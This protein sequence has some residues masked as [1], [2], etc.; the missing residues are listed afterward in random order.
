MAYV[1]VTALTFP[2]G[3]EA[4]IEKRF[5][6]RAK[7]VDQSE[8][9]LGFELWRPQVGESRYFVVTRWD[10]QENYKKWAAAREPGK[11]DNDERRGMSVDVLGFDVVSLN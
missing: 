9:F 5:A 8:G 2:E 7:L 1:N 3:A 11:H 10:S 4:E 6:S